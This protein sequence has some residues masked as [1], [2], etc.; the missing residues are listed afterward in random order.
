MAKKAKKETFEEALGRLEEIAEQL[1]NGNM[2]LDEAVKRYEEGV[3][4]YRYCSS[5][6]KHVERKIE[7]LTQEGDMLKAEEAPDLDP[8]E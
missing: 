8:V 6:L 5:L 1:E 3:R 7:V 2:P 4:A